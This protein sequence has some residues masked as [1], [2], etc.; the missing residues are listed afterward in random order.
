MK[1]L[2]VFLC[3]MMLM[4]NFVL[5]AHATVV[6]LQPGPEGK[7]TWIWNGEDWSHG[8]SGELRANDTSVYNQYVLLEFDLSSFAADIDTVNSATLGLYR[9][10]S[11]GGVTLTLD[12]HQIT[13]S[14]T[15]D[16]IW[17]TQPSYN[18][19]AEASTAVSGIADGWYTWDLTSLT[20]DWIDGTANNYG[21]A[22]FDHGTDYFQRFVS[23][24][25]VGAIEPSWALPPADPSLRPYLEVD[26]LE[27]AYQ[28]VPEPATM[29]LLGSGLIGLAGF[30]RKFRKK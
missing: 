25:N 21:V 12:A 3:G 23:S 20:Q 18:A 9:Y 27:V 5:V 17:S 22:I 1:K 6:T 8:D 26:Y 19:A 7:D 2:L 4:V 14:W 30:R 10:D 11:Y 13:S 15:E 16:V 28:P 24:D 29:L